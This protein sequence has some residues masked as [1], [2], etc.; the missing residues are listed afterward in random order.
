MPDPDYRLLAKLRPHSTTR[1]RHRI[2]LVGR[3][4]GHLTVYALIGY[5]IV[6]GV[7]YWLCRCACGKWAIVNRHKLGQKR[8]TSCG[9]RSAV[10]RTHGMRHSR[11][12]YLWTDML[13][14]VRNQNSKNWQN[15]GGRGIRACEG[16]SKFERFYALLGG[17]PRKY[18]LDRVDN[19]GH[20][21]CGQCRECVHN[22]W[23]KN[24]KWASSKEQNRNRRNNRLITIGGTTQCMAEWCDA[25]GVLSATACYRLKRGWTPEE[26]FEFKERVRTNSLAR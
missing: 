15:Y 5:H 8:A 10:Q 2:T 26:A 11:V 17:P 1:F 21:S 14:R 23:P 9:C 18:S 22:S 20:Y 12:Y 4:Y 7:G 6:D 24:V 13:T 25:T 19:N 16:L 3:R